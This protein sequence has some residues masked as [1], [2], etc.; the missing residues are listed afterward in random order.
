V[1]WK[2]GTTSTIGGSTMRAMRMLRIQFPERQRMRASGYAA[3]A[4]IAVDRSTDAA[5]ITNELRSQRPSSPPRSASPNAPSVASCGIPYGFE[6]YSS[7]VFSPL[8]T[9][10]YRGTSAPAT[11]ASS[12][13]CFASRPGQ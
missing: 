5:E 8:T 4:A 6:R 3:T 2:S 13:R 11:T 12:T 9:M 1:S 10:K 7:S